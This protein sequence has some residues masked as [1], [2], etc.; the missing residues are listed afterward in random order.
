MKDMDDKEER[1]FCFRTY[2][3]SE[4]KRCHVEFSRK[5]KTFCIY[6]GNEANTREHAPSKVFLRKPFPDNLPVL[7]ACKNCNNA[8]SDYE[9]YSEVYLDSLKY[10]SGY[11]ENLSIDNNERIFK[12]TAFYDAQ[13]D[14][15]KY[16][17]TGGIICNEKLQKILIKL[18]ICHAVYEL[19]EGYSTDGKAIELKEISVNFRLNLNEKEIEKFLM[20]IDISNKTFPELGSRIFENI[21]VVEP[22][23]TPLKGGED[24]KLQLVILFWTE[25]QEGEYEYIAWIEDNEI[26]VKIAIHDFLFAQTKFVIK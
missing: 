17:D 25:I 15:K 26:T 22:V 1:Q 4:S 7:P 18:S 13:C 20:P 12:S 2:W 9:L 11:S 6:C 16:I 19:C 3:G 21:R 8:F 24:K 10:L 5:D 14:L 23:L